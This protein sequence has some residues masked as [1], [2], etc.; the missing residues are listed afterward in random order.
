MAIPLQIHV[1]IAGVCTCTCLL[2]QQYFYE[3]F[4]LIFLH[5]HEM[6]MYEIWESRNFEFDIPANFE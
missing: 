2:F 4:Q 6:A 5:V 3:L 1:V